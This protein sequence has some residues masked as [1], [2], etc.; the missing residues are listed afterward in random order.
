MGENYNMMENVGACQ[1]RSRGA[2]SSSRTILSLQRSVPCLNTI[3]GINGL[4]GRYPYDERES[5]PRLRPWHA[6]TFFVMILG[7][8][9]AL[10]VKGGAY[11]GDI[12]T[13]N[14]KAHLGCGLG[15]HLRFSS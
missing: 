2:L 11:G 8:E 1:G 13:M 12:R 4:R 15:T 10:P 6:P 5:A 9:A 3:C 7:I 14:G